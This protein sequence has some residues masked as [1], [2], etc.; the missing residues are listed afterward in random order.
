M[1]RNVDATEQPVMGTPVEVVIHAGDRAALMPLF[2]LADD[3]ERAIAGYF[4]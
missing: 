2:R 3:S 4:R 1:P